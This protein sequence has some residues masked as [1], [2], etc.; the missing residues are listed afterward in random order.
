MEVKFEKLKLDGA[1]LITPPV[2]PD[3]RGFFLERF[4]EQWFKDQGI[5]VKFVQ[6]NQSNSKK[7][8]L[9]GLHYNIAPHAQDKLVWVTQGE[10]FDVVVDIRKSSPT[11]GKYESVILSEKNKQMLFV[12]VGFA[13]GLQV[14]SDYADVHYKVSDYFDASCDK[15]VIWND[16][17]IRID[18][19]IKDPIL[20]D[21]DKA[22][23]LLKDA[24]NLF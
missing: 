8:A 22:H 15:G 17:E 7:G 4:R 1:V 3:D 6:D 16:S 5:D 14:L 11:F 9:R 18:W 19:P 20:S 13:H 10:I 21:K 23:P 24:K 2:Y 12:P